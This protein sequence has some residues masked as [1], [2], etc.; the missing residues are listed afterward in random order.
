[1]DI[2]NITISAPPEVFNVSSDEVGYV[3]TF[4]STPNLF[5]L[6]V[7]EGINKSNYEYVADSAVVGLTISRDPKELSN[8]TQPVVVTLQSQRAFTGQVY[9]LFDALLPWYYTILCYRIGRD[10]CVCHG[11]LLLLMVQV[12]H[13]KHVAKASNFALYRSWKLE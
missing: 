2:A 10:P 3:L 11:T 12:I 7:P 8:L 13:F 4:Y 6:R 9:Y 5:Q 1:M